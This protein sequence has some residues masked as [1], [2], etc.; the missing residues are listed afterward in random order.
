MKIG[1]PQSVVDLYEWL[2]GYGESGISVT[3][4]GLN[5][6][7]TVGYEREGTSEVDLMQRELTFI[8]APVFLRHPFPGNFMFE[9]AG[10]ADGLRLGHLTEFGFS[11]FCQTYIESQRLFSPSTLPEVRHYAV[12]FVAENVGLHVLASSVDVG[13]DRAMVR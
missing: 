1:M 7:V 10:G 3:T 2:P 12:Q 4:D 9:M 6:R 8:Y 11:E 5:L 13:P